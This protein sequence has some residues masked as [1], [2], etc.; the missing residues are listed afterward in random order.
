MITAICLNPA[1]D[2]TLE[3]SEVRLGQVNRITGLRQDIGG[4]GIN[5]AV[6]AKRLGGEVQCLGCAGEEDILALTRMLDREGILSTF[7]AVPGAV[8]TN[9]KVTDSSGTATEFNEAG[10][11]ITKEQ[12]DDFLDM[13]SKKAKRSSFVTLT[14]SL[15]PGCPDTT[16]RDLIHAFEGI[17]CVLDAV[18]SLLLHGLE[19]RPFLVK[20]N[21]PELE[22]TLSK[23]LKTLRDIRDAALQ[24]IRAG[25]GNV[26]VSMGKMGALCTDGKTTLFSPG[27]SVQAKSTVGAGDAMVAG[28]TWA[29][30][31]GRTMA[32]AL[33]AGMAAGAASVMT[34]GTQLIQPEDFRALL[35]RV[36][37]QEV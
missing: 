35:P 20:P 33:K 31:S 17:P 23:E 18:G 8:R 14:G 21:L 30:E 32:E 22:A 36:K 26:V 19:A 4:K 25:A 37:V 9:L 15:P 29:L 6:A 16:Y 11:L 10:S 28:I 5:V 34:E 12:L 13:A 1:Y 27:L 2:K 7:K 24:L 3:V